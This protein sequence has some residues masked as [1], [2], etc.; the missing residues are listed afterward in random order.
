MAV[1][2]L[3]NLTNGL[4]MLS[5]KE[6]EGFVLGHPIPFLAASYLESVLALS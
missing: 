4:E 2:L 5:V 1:G 6:K 3:S